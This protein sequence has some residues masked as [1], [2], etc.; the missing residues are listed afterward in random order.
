MSGGD[1][2][3]VGGATDAG[4]VRGALNN[5]QSIEGDD[6]AVAEK[7]IHEEEELYKLTTRQRKL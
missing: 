5:G 7:I 4:R 1:A 6:L 3:G 2:S